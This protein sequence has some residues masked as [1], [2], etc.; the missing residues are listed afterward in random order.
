MNFKNMQ[1][2]IKR[3]E[4]RIRTIQSSGFI[5]DASVTK[6]KNTWIIFIPIDSLRSVV[7][8]VFYK[9]NSLFHIL[10]NTLF[11]AA[12]TMRKAFNPFITKTVQKRGVSFVRKVGWS[13]QH[14]LS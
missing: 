12:N 4:D 1:I 6:K 9:S 11:Y 2:P 13:R 14:S 8:G 7:K 10:H 5:S 3:L